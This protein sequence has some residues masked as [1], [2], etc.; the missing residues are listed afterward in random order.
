MPLAYS[1]PTTLPALVPTITS[2]KIPCASST[3]IIPTWANPRAPPPPRT[4]PIFSG[5]A[6]GVLSL[7]LLGVVAQPE[8]QAGSVPSRLVPSK[9]A[10]ADSQRRR[11][12]SV[13]MANSGRRQEKDGDCTVVRRVV[14][15]CTK[16]VTAR[17]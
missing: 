12:R 17:F 13:L 16:V 2:G 1:D 14:W 9:E 3:L 6:G 4:R 8:S 15:Q 5:L 10:L 11:E 7:P